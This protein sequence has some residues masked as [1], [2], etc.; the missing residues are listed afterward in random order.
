MRFTIVGTDRGVFDEV[1]EQIK[2]K[3]REFVHETTIAV[4]G[5]LNPSLIEQLNKLK[6]SCVDVTFS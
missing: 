6:S 4:P 1:K 5:E 2:K 3:L